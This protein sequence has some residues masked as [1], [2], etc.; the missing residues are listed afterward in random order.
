MLSNFANIVKDC[1]ETIF[2]AG[3]KEGKQ[4]L[5]ARLE[6]LQHVCMFSITRHISELVKDILK[7]E[8]AALLAIKRGIGSIKS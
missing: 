3:L 8:K 6:V 2:F 7:A 1:Q 5:K 4:S